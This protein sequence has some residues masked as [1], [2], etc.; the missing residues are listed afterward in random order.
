MSAAPGAA[1]AE[2]SRR[3][4]AVERNLGEQPIARIMA[5]NHL[6]RHDLVAVSSLHLTHKMVARACRG[7]RLTQNTK[8]KI[9][10]A[11]NRATNRTHAME[12]LFTY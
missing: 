10:Q 3:S 11:L 8:E 12:E 6:S 7:R 2:A 4:P 9:L 5:D 1:M